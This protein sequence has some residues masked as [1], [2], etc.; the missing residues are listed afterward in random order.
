MGTFYKKQNSFKY[1]VFP[2]VTNTTLN[3][4]DRKL[5]LLII[6]KFKEY[7]LRT[8]RGHMATTQAYLH[9]GL[10]VPVPER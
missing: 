7:I 6:E 1:R 9:F 8:S 10:V 2:G 3:L 4:L 5:L